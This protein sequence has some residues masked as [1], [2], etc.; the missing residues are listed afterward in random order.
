MTPGK[1]HRFRLINAFASVCPSA[2]TIGRHKMKVIATDGAPVQPREF[3][4]IASFTGLLF[5]FILVFELAILRNEIWK[6]KI[7]S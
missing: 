7:Y 2:I 3:D 5:E 4:T 6:K 1:R